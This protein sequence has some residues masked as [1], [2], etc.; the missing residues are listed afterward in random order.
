MKTPK[1]Y[2]DQ[3]SNDSLNQLTAQQWL[4]WLQ[5]LRDELELAIAAAKHDVR[6]AES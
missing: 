5:G 1:Q 2:L 3:A 4:E 6:I